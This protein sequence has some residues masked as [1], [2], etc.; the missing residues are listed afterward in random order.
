MENTREKL[1]ELLMDMP[2]GRGTEEEETAHIESVADYLI[3]NGVTVQEWI[4]VKDRLPEKSDYY[5]AVTD[6]NVTITIPYSAEHK[7]FNAFDGGRTEF[8]MDVTHWMSLPG[9]RK[10]NIDT[11]IC[12]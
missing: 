8:A 10:E 9:R 6:N 5:L 11:I 7:V 4:S 3:A 12:P 1:V 2:Y